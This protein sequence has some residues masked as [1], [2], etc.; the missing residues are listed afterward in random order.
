VT[1]NAQLKCSII[2]KDQYSKINDKHAAKLDTGDY[3]INRMLHA[4]IKNDTLNI[5]KTDVKRK[6]KF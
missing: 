3:L 6:I 2:L 5:K 4:P 1:K